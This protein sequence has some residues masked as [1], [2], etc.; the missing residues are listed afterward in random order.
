[1]EYKIT[2]FLNH[3]GWGTVVDRLSFYYSWLPALSIFWFI[4]VLVALIFDKNNG[5]KIFFSV[6]VATAI[7]FIL[8]DLILKQSFASF[9]FRD[10]PYIASPDIISSGEVLIDS[11]FWSGHLAFTAA[12]VTIFCYFYRRL[13]VYILGIIYLFLMAFSRIHNGMH[14]P[15]DVLVGTIL[16][17][18]YGFLAIF[19]NP[20]KN[21]NSGF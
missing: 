6:L 4:L 18:G 2:Y 13:W 14:Y 12:L 1:M 5:K 16:G 19:L 20:K 10:R 17:I 7:Y 3:L 11:S 8:N 15:S 9:Y 21:K